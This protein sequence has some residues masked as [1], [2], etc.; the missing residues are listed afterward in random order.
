MKK[1]LL[2]AALF[3]VVT[4]EA[5]QVKPTYENGKVVF[6][7]NC[8]RCHGQDGTLGRLGAKNLQVSKLNDAQLREII[9]E[10]SWFM[11][12]WKRVLSPEQIAA[13]MI[14]IKTLRSH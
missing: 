9:S 12:K 4:A 11:P 2:A 10:G 13:V 6:Q 3:C 8:V 1:I 5:Q 7:T 14:Y